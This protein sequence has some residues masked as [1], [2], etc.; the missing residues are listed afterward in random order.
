MNLVKNLRRKRSLR[1]DAPATCMFIIIGLIV[2]LAV[3]YRLFWYNRA[4]E[5]AETGQDIV[6]VKKLDPAALTSYRLRMRDKVIPMVGKVVADTENACKPIIHNKN[7]DKEQAQ[8][9]VNKVLEFQR[10]YITEVNAQKCPIEFE[11]VQKHLAMAI[12]YSWKCSENCK[13]AMKTDD[14]NEKKMLLKDADS[15]LKKAKSYH[16]FAAKEHNR[17]MGTR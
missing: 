2:V 1:G 9:D 8:A 13:K 5:R 4:L 16:K 10:E 12:S 3:C 6:T 7:Y 15:F 14:P 11:K 17:I